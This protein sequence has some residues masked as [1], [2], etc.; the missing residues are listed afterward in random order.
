MSYLVHKS[1]YK[2]CMFMMLFFFHCAR[3][4]IASF[5]FIS[6]LPVLGTLWMCPYLSL[7][8]FSISSSSLLTHC[9]L[10]IFCHLKPSLASFHIGCNIYQGTTFCLGLRHE[11]SLHRHRWHCSQGFQHLH[12]SSLDQHTVYWAPSGPGA[13]AS[14]H[15]VWWLHSSFMVKSWG[16]LRPGRSLHLC[17]FWLSLWPFPFQCFPFLSGICWFCIWRL[18]AGLYICP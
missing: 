15:G 7:P 5:P 2:S 3:I 9:S 8:L 1:N 11:S 10:D 6:S 12:L 16:N 17:F 13:T 4:S 18:N 14:K